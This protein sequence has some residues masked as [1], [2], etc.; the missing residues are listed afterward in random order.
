MYDRLVETESVAF[1]LRDLLQEVLG[2]GAYKKEICRAG[3]LGMAGSVLW[4][5]SVAMCSMYGSV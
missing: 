1:Y 4:V 2:L 3:V 5:T